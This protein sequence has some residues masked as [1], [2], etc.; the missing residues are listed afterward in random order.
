MPPSCCVVG[1]HT[2]RKRKRD[3]GD[4]EKHVEL[5]VPRD[6]DQFNE[7]KKV[8]P[9]STAKSKVCS[10]HFWDY[11]VI[12][13]TEITLRDGSKFRSPTVPHVTKN[14]VP[15]RFLFRASSS[16][17]CERGLKSPSSPN[18][19]PKRCT[20]TDLIVSTDPHGHSDWIEVKSNEMDTISP[21]SS[22][23][24][25]SEKEDQEKESPPSSILLGS[26]IEAGE[27]ESSAHS[28]KS[29]SSGE[30]STFTSSG[31]KSKA[32][33][34]TGSTGS[35]GSSTSETSSSTKS[36]QISIPISK[37]F[38]FDHS[39]SK[40]IPYNL[41]RLMQTYK[42]VLLPT[43]TWSA[44]QYQD[45][46]TAFVHHNVHFETDK[47][48]VFHSSMRPD[49][50]FCKI[51]YP[52]PPLISTKTDLEEFLLKIESLRKRL[53]ECLEKCA[54]TTESDLEAYV[55]KVPKEQQELVKN[56]FMAAKCKSSKGRRYSREFV[57]Q[58]MV[59][60]IKGHALY[61]KLRREN[62]LP[63][64][65]ERTLNKYMKA[66]KPE[67]GFQEKVFSAMGLKGKGLDTS[68][69][70]GCLLLDEMQLDAALCFRADLC[71]VV[72]LVDL[73]KYTPP[74]QEKRQ[75][76]HGL[77]LMYQPFKGQWV[78]TLGAF[79]SSATVPGYIL[80]N[81]ILE[82][83]ILL[84]NQGFTVDIVIFFSPVCSLN[85]QG[86]YPEGIKFLAP[87]LSEL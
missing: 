28:V 45:Q 82:A 15:S 37:Q 7:W 40:E 57:Y 33:G 1:C 42:Q 19:S 27:K 83:V 63:L 67:Y 20:V 60:R 52:D 77:V 35:T 56:I 39:Y 13:F 71:K 48:V 87:I 36:S 3:G 54:S 43:K 78:Q 38:K 86:R 69:R 50:Y 23:Q 2:G 68:E 24:F 14:A 26:E 75:G 46:K 30:T 65:S 17:E 81:I 80:R 21:P 34:S 41:E 29:C 70:H 47:A 76:D 44:I 16:L 85:P 12:R 31:S 22:I 66:L 5:Q 32:S 25:E 4:C 59:M 53:Q 73:E 9:N 84:Y 10:L 8:I 11:E 6:E 18:C 79:L 64:P 49:V 61:R 62:K 58:C 72:G 51:N 55:S 74:D